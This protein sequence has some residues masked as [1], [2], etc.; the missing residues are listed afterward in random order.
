MK[1]TATS[2]YITVRAA[3]S[4]Y[5]TS[6]VNKLQASCTAGAKQA[7]ERLAEKLFG[8]GQHSVKELPSKDLDHNTTKWHLRAGAPKS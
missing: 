8:S 7:A 3:N 6:R 1:N 5:L 2:A 4:T